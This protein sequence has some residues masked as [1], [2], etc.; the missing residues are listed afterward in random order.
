M[1]LYREAGS[2]EE[3]RG[4]VLPPGRASG[5]AVPEGIRERW[6]L[7]L[8]N[9]YYE[10]PKIFKKVGEVDIFIHDSGHSYETMMFEFGI[11]WYHL[12]EEG[13]LLADN[14]NMNTAFKDFTR[15][16]ERKLYWINKL[17]LLMR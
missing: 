15:A 7:F 2:V 5:W 10:L 9:S 4:A 1:F 14:T 12:N 8:G 11:A 6:N 16:K 13:F 3:R 17:A